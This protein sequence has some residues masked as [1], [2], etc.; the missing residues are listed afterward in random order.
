M[1]FQYHHL[2]V[3]LLRPDSSS[4]LK[5]LH[6]SR[7][8]LSVLPNLVS[9]SE[10]VY[11]GIVWQL[12]YYP[13]TPFFVLLNNIIRSPLSIGCDDDLQ[14]LRSTV[15]YFKRM[16]GQG[17]MAGKL[18]RIAG[19]FARLAE[20]CVEDAKKRINQNT[21]INLNSA[22]YDTRSIP[23]ALSERQRPDQA[24]QRRQQHSFDQSSQKNTGT[25]TLV[26][27][28][29]SFNGSAS[30]LYVDSDLLLNYFCA[31]TGPP[32]DENMPSSQFDEENFEPPQLHQNRPQNP[33]QND[34]SEPLVGHMLRSLTEKGRKR[35]LECTFDWFKWDLYYNNQ[36]FKD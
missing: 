12:L 11:N 34:V 7:C 28:T 33:Y 23:V 1:T 20:A 9:T 3:L 30:D 27:T 18:E 17:N 35:P 6:S 15:E 32:L 21:T 19:V 24:A 31:S 16:A 10:E 36:P 8:A 2:L 5:C 13:F 4:I 25:E 22:F 14:L 26:P 29:S